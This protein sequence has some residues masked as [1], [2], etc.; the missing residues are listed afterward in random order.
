MGIYL[1][2]KVWWVSYV[3]RGKRCR[4][5]TGTDNRKLAQR[6]YDK[7]KGEIAEGRLFRKLP[8]E[9]K[10]FR[11]MM[12]KFLLE[13]A[14]KRKSEERFKGIAKNLIS[15]IGDLT[16][17]EITPK[18]VNEYKVKRYQDG[19]K[20]ATINREIAC[21]KKAFNLAYQ[22]WEWIRENPISRVSMEKENNK[23]DRWLSK[24]EE[25]RLLNASPDWMKEL[26]VFALNTGM[27][28]SEILT[29]TWDQIDLNRKILVILN[30]KNNEKRGIPLN[31]IVFEMLK[32]KSKI[33][34]IK[35]N[36]VFYNKEHKQYNKVFISHMFRKIVKKAEINN[37][38]FH[39]LR[40]TF[41]TR[42]VQAGVDIY[43]VSYLLGHK[44]L[45]TTQRYAHHWPE[46]L[47]SAVE[48]LYVTNL[49]QTEKYAN[50][51]N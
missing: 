9:K 47:R 49:S 2:G 17:M 37:F 14:P 27:R 33:R 15:F 12:E 35:A 43:R 11:E 22:E 34:S 41:A 13:Y 6:Y 20:P 26:I 18:V 28:L 48:T 23:R 42:L 32:N 39:D 46:S 29:L 7:I 3:Y 44:D 24:E 31:E 5:S 4:E 8:G 21:L 50:I 51:G 16:I 25:V 45:K 10:T 40:H 36:L 38:R 30:S 19:V 1:R